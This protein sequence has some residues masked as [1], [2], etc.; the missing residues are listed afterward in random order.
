MIVTNYHCMEKTIGVDLLSLF[1]FDR[2]QH[3]LESQEY[4]ELLDEWAK[5][6][7]P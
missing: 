7:I 4:D 1:V 3:Q 2:T 5:K 6:I